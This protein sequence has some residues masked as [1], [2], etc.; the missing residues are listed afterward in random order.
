MGASWLD[1]KSEKKNHFEVSSSHSVQRQWTISQL[2]CD[3]WQKVDFIWQSVV[4]SS[5]VEPRRSCK[6]LPKAKLA[7]KKVM[8][9]VWWSAAEFWWSRVFWILAKPLH[10]RSMLSKLMRCIEN[11]NAY[12]WHWS[13]E[14]AQLSTTMPNHTLH[15]Q[16]FKSWMNL[17]MTLW[18]HLP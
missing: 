4:T 10:L 15:N 16:C 5:V 2:D 13:I 3:V 8:V 7:P 1:C 6:A 11:C 12:N 14:W 18:S 9:T 17:A